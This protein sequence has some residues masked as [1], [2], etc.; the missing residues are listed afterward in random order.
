[1]YGCGR[2][3]I[4]PST[5]GLQQ[6]KLSGY[7]EALEETGIYTYLRYLAF[8]TYDVA[9]GKIEESDSQVRSVPN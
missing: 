1:M 8:S 4:N 5:V 2:V 6:G 9:N 3:I 7:S